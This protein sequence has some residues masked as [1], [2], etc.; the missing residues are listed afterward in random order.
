MTTIWQNF[1]K[2][3]RDIWCPWTNAISI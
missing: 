2:F 3:W 1:I